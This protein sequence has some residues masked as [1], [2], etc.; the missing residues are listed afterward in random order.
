MR[1]PVDRPGRDSGPGRRIRGAGVLEYGMIQS[2]TGRV[3]EV[4]QHALILSP[5]AGAESGVEFEILIP[6]YWTI[7]LVESVGLVVRVFTRLHLESV[8]QGASFTP[9]LL[10]FP[11][12]EDR[13][14]FEAF[15]G[16][17]GLGARRA[18]RAMAVEPGVIAGAIAA[19]DA[20]ALQKLPEIGKRL[21]ETIIAELHGKLD[22]S[23]GIG[24]G[25]SGGA[26]IGAR[27]DDGPLEEA[28]A[29]LIALGQSRAEAEQAVA[30][31]VRG[32]GE[33]GALTTAQIVERAF[34]GA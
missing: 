26:V 29:A 25:T 17:K 8:N 22:D 11:S 18:L 9:R 3:V 16:V 33:T 14:F 10:G 20:R 4:R 13:S 19:R 15:T 27:G 1:V 6:G 31:A 12:A 23:G 32:V 30:R 34:T 24:S 7:R 2:I 5:G 28:V 21:A